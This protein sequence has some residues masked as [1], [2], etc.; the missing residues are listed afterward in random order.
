MKTDINTLFIRESALITD[1][2]AILSTTPHRCLLVQSEN[3][4]LSGVISEG[5]IMRALL[6]GANKFSPVSDWISRD[7]KYLMEANLSEALSIFKKSGISI[8]P[9][10]D[11]NLRVVAIITLLDMLEYV[12]LDNN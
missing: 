1:A 2:L 4:K 10:L 8:L 11:I 3:N 7:Y 9:V 6:N 12:Q 5:D